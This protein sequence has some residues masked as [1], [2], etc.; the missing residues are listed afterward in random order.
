MKNPTLESAIDLHFKTAH[1][2]AVALETTDAT[3]S[4]WRN[5]QRIPVDQCEAIERLTDGKFRAAELLML[6]AAA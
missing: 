3:V 5:G 4:R 2:L 1:A 6:N